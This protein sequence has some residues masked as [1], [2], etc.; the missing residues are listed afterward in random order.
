MVAVL[1]IYSPS[2]DWASTWAFALLLALPLAAF[3][4]FWWQRRRAGSFVFGNTLALRQIRRG[5]LDRTWWIP[6]ALRLAILSL[7]VMAMAR[8]QKPN[9]RVITTKGVDVVIC[10]DMSG[11]MNLVDL[12]AEEI[13]HLQSEGKEPKNRFDVARELLLDFVKNRKGDRIGLVLFG[14]GAYVKFPLTTDYRRAREDIESL[15]L[16]N[17]ERDPSNEDP[18][19]CIN[20][21][22]VP[23][24]A[25][26]IGDA[27]KRAYLRLRDSEASDRS[28]ILITD[29][30]DKGSKM[31]P[32][33]VAEHIR[34]WSKQVDPKT[35]RKNPRI[36]VYT[37]LVGGGEHTY[38]PMLRPDGRLA[39]T[40][41][42][43]RRYGRARDVSVNPELLQT[44]ATET[45]GKAARSYDEEEF[46]K[47]FEELQ[48]TVYQRT[49]ENFPEERF[50]D[51]AWLALALLVVEVLLRLLVYRK[52]P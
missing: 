35:G 17:T 4:A 33:F 44:I 21:C 20:N 25:T 46:R 39:R 3:G 36:R 42:G 41:N 2:W 22:T 30:D 5:W 18:L 16:D 23:G 11:S 6:G 29:G 47:H 40:L 26:T 27:L 19:A 24:N 31:P 7:L 37:F 13:E 28:I 45:G 50:M 52:F 10:L 8:P 51:I 34:D 1:R 43:L 49:V 48:K 15:V 12:P 14:A 9:P 38:G 32:R